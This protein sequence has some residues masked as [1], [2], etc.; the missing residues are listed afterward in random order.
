M[1][2]D[3]FSRRRMLRSAAAG[4]LLFPGIVQQL[5]ADSGD[6][7]APRESHFPAKAKNIIFLFMTGGVSHERGAS[8]SPIG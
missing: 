7:L 6:P 3:P 4:S 2:S 5:M 8:R 1:S